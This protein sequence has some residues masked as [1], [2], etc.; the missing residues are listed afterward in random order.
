MQD[1]FEAIPVQ[2][3]EIIDQLQEH[4]HFKGGLLVANMKLSM[5][6]LHL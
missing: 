5:Y 6:K 1:I 4:V 3:K 2:L